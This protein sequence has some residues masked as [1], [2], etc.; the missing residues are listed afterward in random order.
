[1]SDFSTFFL[2]SDGT[3]SYRNGLIIFL[4]NFRWLPASHVADSRYIGDF[5]SPI[6]GHYGVYGENL[7]DIGDDQVTMEAMKINWGFV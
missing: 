6:N 4:P 2:Y 7:E 1:M 5:Q 3:R